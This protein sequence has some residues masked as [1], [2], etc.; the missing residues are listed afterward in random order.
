MF[1]I[2]SILA[3]SSPRIPSLLSGGLPHRH[4]VPPAAFLPYH[5]LP[6]TPEFLAGKRQ[7]IQYLP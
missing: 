3:P 4:V 7:F 5:H 6:P 1:T 2:D